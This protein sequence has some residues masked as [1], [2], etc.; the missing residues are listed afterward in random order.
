MHTMRRPDRF[1]AR[2][3]LVFIPLALIM[4]TEGWVSVSLAE[5]AHTS[6]ASGGVRARRA[7][8]R[9]K[10]SADAVTASDLGNEL[11]EVVAEEAGKP[12]EEIIPPEGQKGFIAEMGVAAGIQIT[13]TPSDIVRLFGASLLRRL[14]ALTD[15]WK[16]TELPAF[17]RVLI[18]RIPPGGAHQGAPSACV[19]V[20]GFDSSEATAPI[21]F[22]NGLEFVQMLFMVMSTM[23][24]ASSLTDTKALLSFVPLLRTWRMVAQLSMLYYTFLAVPIGAAI[25]MLEEKILPSRSGDAHDE[26]QNRLSEL[27]KIHTVVSGMLPSGVKAKDLTIQ[28]D[29]TDALDKAIA[30]ACVESE[31]PLVRYGKGSA[32]LKNALANRSSFF[33]Q[34][35]RG[36]PHANDVVGE[37]VHHAVTKFFEAHGHSLSV[38][39][40]M[41][42]DFWANEEEAAA[43]LDEILQMTNREVQ[44]AF[45]LIQSRLEGQVS[46]Q[47][48][49]GDLTQEYET[50]E[51]AVKQ[52]SSVFVNRIKE[53][54]AAI[55][56][57]VERENAAGLC[58]LVRN[59]DTEAH[60][61]ISQLIYMHA[62]LRQFCKKSPKFCQELLECLEAEPPSFPGAMT[63]FEFIPVLKSITDASMEGGARVFAHSLSSELKEEAQ[64]IEH[65]EHAETMEEEAKEGTAEEKAEDGE[66]QPAASSRPPAHQPE[67]EDEADAP[68]PVR[69][70]AELSSD[71]KAF[72]AD[73]GN[74]RASLRL[75]SQAMVRMLL[76]TFRYFAASRDLSAGA[77]ARLATDCAVLEEGAEV[78]Q[79]IEEAAARLPS[80]G[81]HAGPPKAD[82]SGPSSFLVEKQAAVP[83]RD[84]ASQSAPASRFQSSFFEG[85]RPFRSSLFSAFSRGLP[86]FA[87]STGFLQTWAPAPSRAAAPASLAASAPAATLPA[88][89]FL[90]AATA[91]GKR[92][93]RKRRGKFRRKR[94]SKKKAKKR[95]PSHGDLA[96][97]AALHDAF[98]YN[99]AAACFAV[100]LDA[101][102]LFKNQGWSKIESDEQSTAA[103]VGSA[104][105]MQSSWKN[106]IFSAN[107]GARTRIAIL[108]PLGIAAFSPSA[109]IKLREHVLSWFTVE[110]KF[111]FKRCST[112]AGAPAHVPPSH[113]AES[114]SDFGFS[115]TAITLLQRLFDETCAFI[116]DRKD[117]ASL[118]VPFALT[119]K[120]EHI[121]DSATLDPLLTGF[122]RLIARNHLGL[123]FEKPFNSAIEAAKAVQ[124]LGRRKYEVAKLVTALGLSTPVSHIKKSFDERGL[125]VWMARLEAANE[126]LMTGNAKQKKLL[127]SRIDTIKGRLSVLECLIERNSL[128]RPPALSACPA[129]AGILAKGTDLEKTYQECLARDH[130]APVKQKR[131]RRKKG[132]PAVGPS[133]ADTQSAAAPES[134][135][136]HADESAV[137]SDA[138]EAAANRPS[139]HHAPHGAAEHGAGPAHSGAGLHAPASESDEFREVSSQAHGLGARHGR[140]GAHPGPKAAA[141][142]RGDPAGS[143]GHAAAAEAHRPEGSAEHHAAE[144]PAKS[145]TPDAGGAG[146]HEAAEGHQTAAHA[147]AGAPGKDAQA[148]AEPEGSETHGATAASHAAH[149][150]HRRKSKKHR[151]K[152]SG[153]TKTGH[154]EG[155]AE[156]HGAQKAH[157]KEAAGPRGDPAG[158]HGHAAAAEA[159]RPEGSAEHHAAES[160]AKSHTPDAGGAGH[161]EAAEGH[162]TA[163]HALA[164]APGKDAQATAE[165]EGSETHGAT[166]A[167]H[168]AHDDHRRKS[169]KHRRKKSGGTKTGHQ[170]GSAESHGAQKAHHKEAAGPR[171]DPAGSHGHAAAA[172]AHR[173][174]G[175]AEHHAAESPA[176]SHTPDAGGAGH[177]EAAEGHQTAAHALAGA[178]GKDAQA[179]AEPEG[180]ETHGATAASHAAHDDHRRKSKKHRRKKSGGT[181]TGHHEGSAESHGA[182]KAHHKEAHEHSAHSGGLPESS[183]T[184]GDASASYHDGHAEKHGSHEGHHKGSRFAHREPAAH[185]HPE[186][187]AEAKRKAEIIEARKK[188]KEAKKERKRLAAER[189]AAMQH[190]SKPR[191]LS[192]K[193]KKRHAKKETKAEHATSKAAYALQLSQSRHD[194]LEHKTWER[195]IESHVA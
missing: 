26:A 163:A 125:R 108:N 93:S 8:R 35:H 60:P 85:L 52:L 152:K 178:P 80:G 73:A 43:M 151:R 17:D 61:W 31:I 58:Q 190:Q 158:S 44:A 135:A 91:V 62:E 39:E 49:L 180:S 71:Q 75:A 131:K 117:L 89:A 127:T 121:P 16:L 7:Q 195:E 2:V 120:A 104:Q 98:R 173:P 33:Q 32:F 143:H 128:L 30:D 165:P 13:F 86:S 96:G 188:R 148:T 94:K 137:S 83:L 68:A 95:R 97:A 162:Q 176:K 92:R 179:T 136:G 90:E 53:A 63:T 170:E 14:I 50:S 181:K 191:G 20:T 129:D 146:H 84:E 65:I 167:S 77:L 119:E 15:Y 34:L 140:A 1:F 100:A 99:R 153:G 64:Q 74:F 55:A 56:K 161:H 59:A 149:D 123:T 36:G 175:S 124:S 183:E 4:S 145:H 12:V 154:Q 189:K 126:Q 172:E 186:G 113:V 107:A 177:H 185:D 116:T 48:L 192:K 10:Q 23:H 69:S 76:Q 164:G 159:H 22:A 82:A 66:S 6:P 171:G 174:E 67:R 109:F 169:K 122:L 72:L 166:A 118:L 79:E 24:Q 106:R 133:D 110:V 182:Q 115:D 193:Q 103:L 112:L 87:A 88:A 102:K 138:S 168:A 46:P 54:E 78:M 11:M 142:P 184:H 155:S 3:L 25:R 150:D 147:L 141:D 101:G 41:K 134:A 45:K 111:L 105:R 187:D 194:G 156:S 70:R 132:E 19:S 114:L 40:L 144:S 38:A 130:S 9:I 57:F 5:A 29:T 42:P 157:H 18:S 27:K 28:L 160:P 81:D 51:K 139:V 47:E 21:I 37:L